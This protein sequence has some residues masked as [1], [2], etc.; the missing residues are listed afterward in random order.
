MAPS[1]QDLIDHLLAEIA[2]CGDQ[3]GFLFLTSLVSYLLCFFPLF[4]HVAASAP[5]SLSIPSVSRVSCHSSNKTA[6]H[7]YS[8]ASSSYRTSFTTLTLTNMHRRIS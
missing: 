5:T 1:L 8:L 3:G 2:L 4:L 6:R 7:V